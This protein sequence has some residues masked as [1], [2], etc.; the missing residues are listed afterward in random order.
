MSVLLASAT[1]TWGLAASVDL[2]VGAG[3]G[4]VIVAA[5]GWAR[6]GVTSAGQQQASGRHLMP[7]TSEAVGGWPP[8]PSASDA[9]GTKV[10]MVREGRTSAHLQEGSSRAL[11]R[12]SVTGTPRSSQ[13]APSKAPSKTAGCDRQIDLG[14]SVQGRAIVAC[15][16]RGSD[17][18]AAHTVLVIGNMHGDE[19]G[20]PRVVSRLTAMDITGAKADVWVIK[21]ANPDGSAMDIRG[22]ANKVDLNRNFPARGW[23]VQGADTVYYGGLVAGSEPETQALMMAMDQIRP[24]VVVVFH[25]QL[26]VIDCT[27]NRSKVLSRTLHDL[28]GYRYLRPPKCLPN[29]VGQFTTWANETYA[30][31]SAVIFELEAHPPGRRLDRVAAAMVRLGRRL[32]H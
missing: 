17:D 18:S 26:N 16:L 25:Q 3:P 32:P 11:V 7:V 23:Q 30:A 27:T 1:Q 28:T 12:A 19:P 31:T 4:P 22:N 14:P 15:R 5:G 9:R 24:T 2:V 13:L 10:M 21:T 29:W 8:W 6:A 20:G